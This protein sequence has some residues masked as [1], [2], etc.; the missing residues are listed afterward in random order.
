MKNSQTLIFL[1]INPTV[2]ADGTVER[3]VKGTLLELVNISLKVLSISEFVSEILFQTSSSILNILTAIKQ[4]KNKRKK[5][6]RIFFCGRQEVSIAKKKIKEFL[7]KVSIVKK[8]NQFFFCSK[9]KVSIMKKK[10]KN[11]F[12]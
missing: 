8:K 6:Q 9:R 5:N 7:Q 1:A 2:E 11:S 4:M 3:A 10:S 12:L